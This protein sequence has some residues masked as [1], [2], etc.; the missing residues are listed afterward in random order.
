MGGTRKKEKDLGQGEEGLAPTLWKEVGWGWSRSQA[1][2]WLCLLLQGHLLFGFYAPLSVGAPA[3][4]AAIAE[5]HGRA[6]LL[7]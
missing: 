4:T 6:G 2:P 3:T 1:Q 5:H 7:P